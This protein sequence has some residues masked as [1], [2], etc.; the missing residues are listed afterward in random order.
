MNN[1]NPHDHAVSQATCRPGVRCPDS[2]HVNRPHIK[3][4]ITLPPRTTGSVHVGETLRK[5]TTAWHVASNRKQRGVN[6]Q[7]RID[8]A[9]LK[10]KSLYPKSLA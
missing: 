3:S 7:F 1:R 10:L 8:E 9:R 4:H 6:W 5:E 2:S